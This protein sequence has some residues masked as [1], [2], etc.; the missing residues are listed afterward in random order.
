MGSPI[1]SCNELPVA[2]GRK[3]AHP[4]VACPQPLT[5]HP[6]GCG[7]LHEMTSAAGPIF[8]YFHQKLSV[9]SRP[10]IGHSA[11]PCPD[12]CERSQESKINRLLCAHTAELHLVASR[13]DFDFTFFALTKCAD[14]ELRFRE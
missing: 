11:F 9:R 7:Y 5:R 4:E 1:P 12:P 3:A 10:S 14:L 6:D 8:T 2:R 13:L